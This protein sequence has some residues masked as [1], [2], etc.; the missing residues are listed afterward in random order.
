MGPVA[1]LGR[2][3][4]GSTGTSGDMKPVL[5]TGEG[6]ADVGSA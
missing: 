6:I 1:E 3:G 2:A 5:E 4:K